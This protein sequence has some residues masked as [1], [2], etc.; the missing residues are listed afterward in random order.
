MRAREC[1]RDLL[2]SEA[3]ILDRGALRIVVCVGD[4]AS[5]ELGDQRQAHHLGAAK[6]EFRRKRR[7]LVEA[8]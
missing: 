7:Q 4:A 3:H 8:P 5:H 2:D 1:E 6:L